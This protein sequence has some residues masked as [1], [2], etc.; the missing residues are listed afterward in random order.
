METN[1]PDSS[2]ATADGRCDG[3]PASKRQ[4]VDSEEPLSK[5]GAVA[6]AAPV[7]IHVNGLAGPW[8]SLEASTEWSI[9]QVH[10]AI[11]EKHN[12][13][14]DRQTLVMDT[15]KL[16][17]EV[18]LRSLIGED[19]SRGLQLSLVVEEVPDP[20][21]VAMRQPVLLEEETDAQSAVNDPAP[22]CT[23]Q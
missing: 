23:V 15:R 16:T 7:T 5:A 9:F 20:E 18:R 2:A 10:M 6:L 11:A 4:R 3:E 17:R 21:P 1:L 8:C 22:R 13:P 14:I 12:I 19:A